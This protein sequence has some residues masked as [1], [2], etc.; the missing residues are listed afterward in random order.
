M[1]TPYRVM[2]LD[3]NPGRAALLEEAL[4]AEG[5]LVV[6]RVAPDMDLQA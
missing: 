2:L 1:S 6:S 3:R 5:Y 4:E